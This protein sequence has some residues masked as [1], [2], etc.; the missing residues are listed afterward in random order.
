MDNVSHKGIFLG[1]SVTMNN[2]HSH[3]NTNNKAHVVT[4]KTYDEAHMTAP[5]DSQ[6]LMALKLQPAG[7]INTYI[8]GQNTTVPLDDIMVKV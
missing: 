5:A 7:Y 1:Y 4:H 6:P 8:S 3:N 2:F